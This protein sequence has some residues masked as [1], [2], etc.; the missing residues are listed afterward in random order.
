M[1]RILLVFLSLIIWSCQDRID[2]KLL[3]TND[4][5]I[6]LIKISSE[7]LFKNFYFEGWLSTNIDNVN[8]LI[9]YDSRYSFLYALEIESQ[10]AFQIPLYKGDF[11]GYLGTILNLG[12]NGSEMILKSDLGLFIY[13]LDLNKQEAKKVNELVIRRNYNPE[14]PLQFLSTGTVDMNMPINSIPIMGGKTYSPVFSSFLESETQFFQTSKILMYD[15]KSENYDTA[16]LPYPKSYLGTSGTNY[17][18]LYMPFFTQANEKEFIVNYQASDSLFIFDFNGQLTEKHKISNYSFEYPEVKEVIG[19]DIY[20][21]SSLDSYE[22]NA[23]RFFPLQK[24]PKDDFY[25]IVYKKPTNYEKPEFY[26][27]RF[28]AHVLLILDNDFSVRAAVD[29]PLSYDAAIVVNENGIY[30]P[31]FQSEIEDE[32]WFGFISR[33]DIMKVF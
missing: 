19:Y 33:E 4:L 32:I 14:N 26:W 13:E 10:K 18:K 20:R 12:F 7:P 5:P 25:A 27:N 6:E 23:A 15:K 29:L 16:Q 28:D 11:D 1:H 9:T 21:D 24:D 17:P 22:K 8:Y 3:V 2:N 31:Y 30:L